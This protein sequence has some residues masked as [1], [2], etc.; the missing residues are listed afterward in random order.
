MDVVVAEHG[1][2]DTIHRYAHHV[3]D[4]RFVDLS[5]LFTHDG[6]FIIDRFDEQPN[7]I[8]GR[9]AIADY[10]AWSADQRTRDPLRGPYRRHH[11]SSV[12][13]NLDSATSARAECYFIAVMAHGVD[14][15][16]RYEDDLQFVD[17]LWRFARRH[18]RVDGRV[19]R[20]LGA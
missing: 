8:R 4:G 5:E 20:D 15:W 14:H 13:V 6:E 10:L 3:D 11:V 2:R 9:S 7:P 19:V 16:G 18:V 12:L 1:I 17:D